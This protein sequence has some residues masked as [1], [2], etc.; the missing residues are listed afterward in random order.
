M[1][2]K[3]AALMKKYAPISK[4]QLKAIVIDYAS[5]FPDW[6]LLPEGSGIVRSLGPVQQMIWF[7]KMSSAAYRPTHVMNTTVSP[8]P[9]MLHQLL[10]VKHREIEVGWHE[11]KLSQTIIA[12][13][14]Q[15]RPA[16]RR[17]LNVAEILELCEIE[18]R[19]DSLNDLMM[20]AILYAWFERKTEA[21]DC[22]SRM[23]LCPLPTL[24]PAPEWEAMMRAFG[25][26]LANAVENGNGRS[27][28]EAAIERQLIG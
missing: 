16:I 10:D 17:P 13:E 4:A 24:A 18:S 14:Q 1:S 28:L 27:F 12:M 21:L 23:Q 26:Q 6:S 15:F 9:R 5:M 7:Q 8:M 22:C 20:L 11:R 2:D 3:R 25:D 19:R